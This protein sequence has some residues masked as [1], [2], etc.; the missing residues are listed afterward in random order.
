MVVLP[1]KMVLPPSKMV[2][3][4]AMAWVQYWFRVLSLKVCGKSKKICGDISQVSPAFCT[5]A[6]TPSFIVM[7][8]FVQ[9]DVLFSLF[10]VLW[11]KYILSY[12]KTELFLPC[13]TIWLLLKTQLLFSHHLLWLKYILSFFK[14]KFC[15]FTPF[16]SFEKYNFCLFTPSGSLPTAA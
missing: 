10:H 7:S 14:Q 12:L 15:L 3:P 1:S 16:D 13:H 2:L 9:H 4:Q 5:Y 6:L 8:F 11:S